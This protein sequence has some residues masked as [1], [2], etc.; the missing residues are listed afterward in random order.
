MFTYASV[1]NKN[2]FSSILFKS[3]HIA[4]EVQTEKLKASGL[5]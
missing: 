5:I 3:S 4:A 2:N 1:K